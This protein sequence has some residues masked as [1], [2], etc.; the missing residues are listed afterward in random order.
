LIRATFLQETDTFKI[1]TSS[2]LGEIKHEE[3]E[4]AILH[5]LEHEQ[6]PTTRTNLCSSLCDLISERAVEIVRREIESGYDRMMDSLEERLLAVAD[7]LNV[8]L[9]EAPRWRAERE[10]HRQRIAQRIAEL[11]K[12]T[13]TPRKETKSRPAPPARAEAGADGGSLWSKQVPF[14]HTKV[15]VGRNDPCPCGSGKKYKKCCGGR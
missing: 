15:R 6:H 2:L 1:Y 5:L 3:S 4:A 9:P 8:S 11:E 7:M 12:W 14:Q 10:E 13:A